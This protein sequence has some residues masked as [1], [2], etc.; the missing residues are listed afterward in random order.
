M[1]DNK[2]HITKEE[3]YDKMCKLGWDEDY[4][5]EIIDRKEKA[6]IKGIN[7]PLEMYLFEA[8]IPD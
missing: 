7:I 1:I 3:F 5:Y 2:N 6:E 4:I 8:P